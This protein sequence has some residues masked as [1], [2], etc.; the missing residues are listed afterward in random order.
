VVRHVLSSLDRYLNC[1]LSTAASKQALI[2][3]DMSSGTK[4]AIYAF[5]V[6]GVAAMGISWPL[7]GATSLV[8]KIGLTSILLALQVL[9]A[10]LYRRKVDV[11]SRGGILKFT[12][13]PWGYRFYFLL[14]YVLA[15]GF[16]LVQM[17]QH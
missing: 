2:G 9:L 17:S 14:I 15:Y 10:S 5:L 13:H 12:D 8:F 4:I 16:W 7:L 1:Q 3:G 6:G 11:Y